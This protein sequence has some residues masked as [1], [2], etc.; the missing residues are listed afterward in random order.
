MARLAHNDVLDDG[1]DAMRYYKEKS[2]IRHD[3][4]PREVGLTYQGEIVRIDR[5]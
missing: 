1:L 5:V 3:A 4:N 2:V